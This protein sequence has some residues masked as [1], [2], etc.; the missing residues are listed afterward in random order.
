MRLVFIHGFGETQGI[1]DNIAPAL[2][3]EQVFVSL[4][5]T[6]GNEKRPKLNIVDFA[7]ELVHQY[8]ID[9]KDIII[10]HSLGGWLAYH[11]KHVN[12]NRI[13]QIASWTSPRKIV[14]PLKNKKLLIWMVKNGL[15]FNRFTKD[16]LTKRYKALPSE[17]L[18]NDIID[19][20]INA[21]RTCLTNQLK[22]VLDTAK[23][24]MDITPDLRIHAKKDIVIRYPDEAFCEVPGDHFTLHTHP[25]EVIT[26]IQLF[27]NTIK[28]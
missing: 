5:D 21:N 20:M 8:K 9:R 18:Y 23:E 27:L 25:G 12:G 19:Q 28:D 22:L 24:P 16:F 4:W 10:G 11:I 26:P 7:K 17:A 13:V 6:L 15:V 1:F 2:P 3:G 14:T